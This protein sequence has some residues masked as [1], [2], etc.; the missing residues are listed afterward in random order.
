MDMML[1]PPNDAKAT[2]A[3]RPVVVTPLGLA[4]VELDQFVP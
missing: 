1:A 2:C 3:K 4:Q